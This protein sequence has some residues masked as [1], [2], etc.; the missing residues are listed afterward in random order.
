MLWKPIKNKQEL[1]EIIQI[2]TIQY[3]IEEIYLNIY[4]GQTS[5]FELII[6]V[7]NKY[8]KALDTLV[9]KILNSIK[10]YPQYKIRCYIAFQAKN[11]I[12]AG[13]LFLFTTCQP[14][15]LIYKKEGSDFVPI[16]KNMNYAKCKELAI[17]LRDQEQQK[18]DEF[19]EGYYHFKMQ[20]KYGLASFMLHQAIELTYRYLELLLVAKERITHS[21]RIHHVYLKSISSVYT[22]VFDENDK[23]D[24]LL[25]EVL[26]DI[27]RGARYE[28][29]FLIYPDILK[30][31]E[32]KM[33][34]LHVNAKK[35]STY[36]ISSFD[37]QY[38]TPSPVHHRDCLFT[39]KFDNVFNYNNYLKDVIEQMTHD[40]S[41]PFNIYVFG[42]HCMSFHIDSIVYNDEPSF[43]HD[44]YFNL[45]VISEIDIKEQI[46]I[47][48]E[49]LNKHFRISVSL[50]FF[51]KDQVQKQLDS[52]NPYFHHLLQ[53]EEALLYSGLDQ[54][55]W[56]FHIK[57]GVHTKDD[58][59][60]LMINWYQRENNASGFLNGGM[61]IE[62]SEEAAIK[63]L[64]YHKS[65]MQALLGLLEYF[66][67]YTP[68]QQKFKYLYNLCCN[69]CHFPN[70]IFP[71]FTEEE[72]KI[73]N[74]FANLPENV[75]SKKLSY[76]DWEETFRYEARCKRFLKECSKLVRNE[77]SNG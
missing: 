34:K 42:H 56:R 55:E 59:E 8:V 52:N 41:E 17:A 63:V 22:G 31:L 45:M 2:L 26:E 16:P 14:Q 5:L 71:R 18:V 47:L 61:G 1:K 44:D 76:M 65:M 29:D 21:I 48:Q 27:Y 50:L 77:T 40:I 13:N 3:N 62:H 24:I 36:I 6:L 15:K 70:D 28:N 30:H 51:T 43:T 58:I 19:K 4:N 32:L 39:K 68:Y 7:S 73:F 35:V 10:E 60:K 9:P 57:N 53:K 38:A 67:G 23:N 64:L 75:H 69:F 72:K 20:G 66:L 46:V 49:E 11:S 74:E 37:Q 12:G 54:I 33:E 25:L